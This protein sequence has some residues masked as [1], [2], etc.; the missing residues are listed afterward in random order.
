LVAE[1]VLVTDLDPRIQAL[2]N[3]VG[4]GLSS[5]NAQKTL[6]KKEE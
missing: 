2:L 1:A 4:P 3:L 5:H 6:D